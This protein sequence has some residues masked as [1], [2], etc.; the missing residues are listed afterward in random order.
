MTMISSLCKSV[1]HF[2]TATAILLLPTNGFSGQPIASRDLDDVA[3][4][5]DELL[6]QAWQ[7]DQI[8]PAAHSEDA[9]FCRRVW[10][11]LA[12]VAP[13]VAEIRRF[14]HDSSTDKRSHLIDR[15]LG[16]RRHAIHMASRW[17]D[18]LLPDD[19]QAIPQANN[20][21][22]SLHQWL[23]T[24]FINN[25]RYDQIVADLLT[26]KGSVDSGPSVFYAAHTAEP[27]KLAAATSRIFLGLQLQCA[28]CHDHPFDRWTQ[29]DFWAY[30]AFFGQVQQSEARM[31]RSMVI[32]D[33]GDGEVTLPDTEQVVPPRYPGSTTDPEP[34]PLGI[35]RRQL[36][37]W[38]ASRDNPY[39][40]RAAA[41]RVWGQMFGHGLVEPVDAMDAA[42]TPSHPEVLDLLA[43]T[44]VQQRF[45]LRSLYAVI[46]RTQA[47]QVSSRYSGA[48]DDRPPNDSFAVMAVKTLTAAQFYDSMQQN[49][50]RTTSS[51]D[52]SGPMSIDGRRLAYLARM[53]AT[54]ATPRDYPHGIVQA[55][56]LI[57]GPEIL[58][59]SQATTQG[60][61][62]AVQADFFSDQQRIETLFLATLSRYPDDSEA[63]TFLSH[64]S[65]A[66]DAPSRARA[67]G[68]VVWVLLNTAECAMCP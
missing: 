28:Q 7:R 67:L 48:P 16:T 57:N 37:I 25:V 59:A 10:L 40:A 26:A 11:D 20:G 24:Q 31:N 19:T 62:G 12:G 47:Y 65:K 14:L 68:D 56:G 38:M 3:S 58:T 30:A 34:D 1:R 41:N 64:L 46:A 54:S 42:N 39:L 5:I 15:L 32:V 21:I 17:V 44:L 61:L 13:P 49:I 8:Q 53:R 55:L 43:Q 51:L 33:R 50:Y 63:K 52:A 35:R 29:E 23:Q 9:E 4:Q 60:I 2:V 6:H 45:D 27:E 66:R 22:Q 36:T 18:V